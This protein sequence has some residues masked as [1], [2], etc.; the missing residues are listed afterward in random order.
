MRR[1][2]VSSAIVATSLLA[3]CSGT[4]VVVQAALEP[5]GEQAAEA[6][7][8]PNLEVRA[9]PYDRDAIFDSLRAAFDTP[10]PEIPDSLMQLQTTITEAQEQLSNAEAQWNA[11]RDSLKTLSDQME[12]MSRADPRYVIAFRDFNA[13]ERIERQQQ[14][15]MEQA[16][17]R[18]TSVLQA[19]NAQSQEIR[20]QRLAWGDEAFASINDVFEARL[21]ELGIEEHWDTT[22]ANGVVTFEGLEPGQW[23]IH[24][25]YELPYTELYWN[26]PIEVTRG[27]P[28]MV[29][30]NRAAAQ[31]RPKL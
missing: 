3:A 29:T 14:Q 1:L 9:L 12:G 5:E 13:Q 22:N 16:N 8:L 30:L 17:Q 19:F 7:P 20:A 11:A 23:W 24:A 4:E 25:R 31:V 26:E 21:E 6:S 10:E 18:F 2:V 28:I 27:E 15:R